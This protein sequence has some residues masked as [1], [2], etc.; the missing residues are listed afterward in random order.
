MDQK[1]FAEYVALEA[2]LAQLEDKKQAM[3]LDILEDLK[4]S[5]L[6]KV[7]SELFGTF[8]VAHKATW[9]YSDAV[10]KKQEALKIAQH[11]EQEKGIATKIESDYLLFKPAK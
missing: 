9:K 5:G 11:K 8:T 3:R 2:Q 4:K 10:L 7:E 1:K 6:E